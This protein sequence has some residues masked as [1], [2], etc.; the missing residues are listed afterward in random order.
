[1]ARVWIYDR[2]NDATYRSA[3]EKA[4]KAKKDPP[5]R[6]QVRWYDPSGKLKTKTLA[7]KPDAERRKTDI[8][9]SLAE[10]SYRDPSAGKARF[11][12]VA[13]TWLAAQ[14]D[15]K[16]SSRAKYRDALD[17]HILERWGDL[18]VSA[19]TFDDVAVWVSEL[20]R[21]RERGGK[22]LGAS[23][24]RTVY[25]VLS[26]VLDWCVPRRLAANPAKGVPLPKLPPSD[27]VYLT[28]VQVEALATAAGGLRTK[29]DRPTAAARVNRALI[30]LLAYTGL[31]WDEAS[32][33]RVGRVDLDKRRIQVVTAFNEVDGELYEDTPK[34]GERRAVPIPASLVA[35]L[36]PLIDGRDPNDLVFTSA[37]GN[38]LRLRNWRRREFL[39]ARKAAGLDA[40]DLTPHKLRHTAASLAIA[41]RADVYVV[42][43][44]LGHAKPSMTLD[45]Y[46]HLWPDR[47]DEVADAMDARRIE[48]MAEAVDQGN[49]RTA[50]P[51]GVH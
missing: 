13:E 14:S 40:L 30:L 42:Q 9:N 43:R 19:I 44:M 7:K 35:E 10:G 31:R 3:V 23:Q 4:R 33:L 20:Q 34:T 5:G 16:R 51:S 15:L 26:M 18:P 28:Y 11:R 47:L 25:S 32:A 45:V 24:T 41:A 50:A 21:S 48:A 37:R 29:Y 17:D 12:D 6:W 1:M 49:S 22:Q 8:E 36:K 38:A 27:H 46:G 2:T 39:P